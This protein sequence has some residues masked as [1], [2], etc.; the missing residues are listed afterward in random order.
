MIDGSPTDNNAILFKRGAHSVLDGKVVIAK[1][2]DTRIGA[3]IRHSVKWNSS[4][5]A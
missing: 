5:D 2:Y 3:P 1:E 4:D